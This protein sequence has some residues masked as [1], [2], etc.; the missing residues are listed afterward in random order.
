MGKLKSIYD[1]EKKAKKITDLARKINT[2]LNDLGAVYFDALGERSAPD[3]FK[4]FYKRAVVRK[5][6]ADEN[7]A[8]L[9]KTAYEFEDEFHEV[10]KSF[11][12]NRENE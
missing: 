9:L 12:I 7:V 10:V 5:Q 8:K 3:L 11:G 2:A 1:L 6:M 4:S